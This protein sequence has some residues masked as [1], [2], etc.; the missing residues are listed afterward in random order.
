MTDAQSGAPGAHRTGAAVDETPTDRDS[1]E[2][3]PDGSAA[4][5]S[6]TDVLPGLDTDPNGG[7]GTTRIADKAV[8][9]IAQHS[10]DN[11]D[12]ASGAAR[13]VLGV[14]VGS[15]DEDTPARVH[16][17]VDG[18]LVSVA[19]S[20]A[21]RWPESV[22]QVTRQARTAITQDVTRLTGM[23]VAE[24]DITVPELLRVAPQPAGPR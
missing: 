18:D 5:G 19:V 14:K 3:S 22:R 1:G 15:L 9:K 21:V 20:M 2:E 13:H 24:V 12:R 7:P 23:R 10:V 11:V 17:T 4:A 8:E 6:L 16:A